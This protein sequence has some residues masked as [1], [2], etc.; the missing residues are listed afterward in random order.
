MGDDNDL[1]AYIPTFHICLPC[2]MKKLNYQIR[3][4]HYDK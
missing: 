3:V 1:A 4:S 2:M